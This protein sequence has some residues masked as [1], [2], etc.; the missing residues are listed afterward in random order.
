MYETWNINALKSQAIAART[1]ALGKTPKQQHPS[2]GY[3]ICD[4]DCCQVWKPGPYPSTITT[5]VTDTSGI[6]IK[7]DGKLID[8]ANFFSH[9]GDDQPAH[10]TRNSENWTGFYHTYLRKTITP[11]GDQSEDGG[12]SVGMSQYGAQELANIG[13]THEDIL[14]YYYGPVPPYIV[15]VKVIQGDT[16]YEACWEDDNNNPYTTDPPSPTR[17]FVP[18]KNES[19]NKESDVTIIIGLSER[20]KVGENEVKMKIKGEMTE[21]VDY[22]DDHKGFPPMMVTKKLTKE[23]LENIGDGRYRIEIEARHRDVDEWQLD[24]NPETFCYQHHNTDNLIGYDPGIDKNHIIIIGTSTGITAGLVIDRSGSM[25]ENDKLPKAKEAARYFVDASE[26]GDE[27]AI[28]AFDDQP[29]LVS[30]LTGIIQRDPVNNPTK[31][32][33]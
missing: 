13:L 25:D 4:E 12:H 1:L 8:Y 30:A 27:I 2:A 3:D 18:S 31:E 33:V 10:Y 23:Q 16:K 9:A 11:E 26:V 5:A 32:T 21:S 7:Y 14:K 22:S 15:S 19:L 29:L 28:S 17:K 20:V 6:G 24:S